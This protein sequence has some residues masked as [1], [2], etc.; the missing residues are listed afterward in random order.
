MSGTPN[1][2]ASA[3]EFIAGW[4]WLATLVLLGVTQYLLL[5]V[6]VLISG[7]IARRRRL[8]RRWLFV[9][10]TVTLAFGIAALLDGLVFSPAG[11]GLSVAAAE[12]LLHQQRDVAS[13]IWVLCATGMLLTALLPCL[14]AL[15][16]ARF[17][18]A[19]WS[20]LLS[21]WS[22]PEAANV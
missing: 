16:F 22:A 1:W 21:A 19:R 2:T 4:W 7:V 15:R 12:A 13:G 5:L 3:T 10:V 8:E 17:L 6:P 11:I 9:A 20:A 14:F 18:A